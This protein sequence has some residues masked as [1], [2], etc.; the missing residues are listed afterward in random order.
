M[1]TPSMIEAEAIAPALTDDQKMNLLLLVRNAYPTYAAS[2]DS[3]LETYITA[4]QTN[5]TEKTKALKAVLTQLNALPALDVES[6]GDVN[7]P[8]FFS[9][10]QNWRGLA[11]DVLNV[12]KISVSLGFHQS[13]GI[14]QR[15]I[16][17]LTLIDAKWAGQTIPVL[18]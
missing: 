9:T 17:D 6:Q 1:L 13:W 15:T 16:E 7:S 14:Q 11:L 4:E 10:T 3:S 18:K 5:A 12:F 2:W 8:T